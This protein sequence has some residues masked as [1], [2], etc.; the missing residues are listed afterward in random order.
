MPT[1]YLSIV[2]SGRGVSPES[3]SFTESQLSTGDAPLDIFP[4]GLVDCVSSAIFLTP[5][6]PVALFVVALEGHVGC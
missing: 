3:L 5:S 1:C 4:E 6:G 2:V